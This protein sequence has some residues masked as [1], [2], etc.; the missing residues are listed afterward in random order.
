MNKSALLLL[1][2]SGLL[3]GCSQESKEQAEARFAVQFCREQAKKD[4]KGDP[5][6][7]RFLLEA[8]ELKAQEFRDKYG[9][10]P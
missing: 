6:L 7:E 9:M 4:A 8:C 5:S 2:I 10:E 1:V 3:I